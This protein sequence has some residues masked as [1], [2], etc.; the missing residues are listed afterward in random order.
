MRAG[1][2]KLNERN[3]TAARPVNKTTRPQRQREPSPRVH[4][5]FMY[6]MKHT[7]PEACR[8]ECSSFRSP[9]VRRPSALPPLFYL[10]MTY[11]VKTGEIGR[12]AQTGAVGSSVRPRSVK[13]EAGDIG[14]QRAESK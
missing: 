8:A 2:I 1:G 4:S 9:C 10:N 11:A 12:G 5:S 7:E 14:C 3:R 13:K 6:L